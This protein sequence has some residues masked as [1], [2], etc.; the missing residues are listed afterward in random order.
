MGDSIDSMLTTIAKAGRHFRDRF[1]I[2]PGMSEANYCGTFDERRPCQ[3]NAD[4]VEW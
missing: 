4:T 3:L 2:F 1:D